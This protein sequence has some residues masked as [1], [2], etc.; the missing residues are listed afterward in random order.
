MQQNRQPRIGLTV[1]Y[2]HEGR[3][4]PAV[5]Q[6]V[7][8]DRRVDLVVFGAYDAGLSYPANVTPGRG[9]GQWTWP[10]TEG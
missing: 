9:D 10:A 7:G 3:Q 2:H 1:V 4:Y 8:K 6:R 5:I